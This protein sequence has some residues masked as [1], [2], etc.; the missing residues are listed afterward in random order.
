MLDGQLLLSVHSSI[1]WSNCSSISISLL[2]HKHSENF[3]LYL[4]ILPIH[5]LNYTTP[6][7]HPFIYPLPRYLL[8]IHKFI[9][10][11]IHIYPSSFLFFRLPTHKDIHL[12][13]MYPNSVC[14][15]IH[16]S[17]P[18]SISLTIYP[19]ICSSFCSPALAIN[20]LSTYLLNPS[21][22]LFTHLFSYPSTCLLPTHLSIYPLIQLS[23]LHSHLSIHYPSIHRFV[24]PSAHPFICLLFHSSIHLPTLPPMHPSSKSSSST[25]GWYV[26]FMIAAERSGS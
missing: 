16:L 23:T 26:P 22:D 3:P 8:P 11:S 18:L 2:A 13:I 17:I 12:S 25:C 21:I 1:H 6:H 10:S 5:F 7:I 14:P 24:H 19:S 15:F 4:L 9:Y 20:H